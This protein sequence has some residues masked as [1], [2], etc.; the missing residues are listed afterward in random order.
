MSD[1]TVKPPTPAAGSP[2]PAWAQ[3][4]RSLFRSGSVAQFIL[5]GNIFD[6][7]PYENRQLSLK[8]FLDEVMFSGY[9]AVLQY[10]RS[11]GIRAT[12]G[13][14]DW[15]AWLRQALGDAFSMTQTREPGAALELLD[16]YL[17]R[18][19][20]L[21]AI[22]DADRS[23]RAAVP[24]PPS[25][26]AAAPAPAASD[27][28]TFFSNVPASPAAAAPAG[29]ASAPNE[30]SAT[31]SGSSAASG[32][33]GASAGAG[34]GGPGARAPRKIAVII[35]FAE[36]VVPQGDAIQL[37]GAFSANIVKVLG[38][39]NDPAI[40]Q[41][42]IVTVLLVE[43]LHDL[44]GLVVD[45]AEHAVGLTVVPATPHDEKL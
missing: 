2:L 20:N 32:A 9:D 28:G 36:F 21:Q 43:G 31:P 1:T 22:A 37:G 19:L 5:H 38:W 39:A 23:R 16:R 34:S 24:P 29:P 44:N 18:T 11:R 10:D 41:S 4:M 6:I 45:K 7:V 26:S 25:A 12:R 3:E 17:L 33:P 15:T 35:D 13:N 27:S 14:D 40:L 30:G 8:N 42:N